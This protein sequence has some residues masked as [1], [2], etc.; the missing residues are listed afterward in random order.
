MKIIIDGTIYSSAP[1]GGVYRYFNE[2]IPRLSAFPDTEVNI[3]SPKDAN[4]IPTGNHI[5]IEKD[6]LPSGSWLPEGN[7]KN[8]LRKV[9]QRVNSILMS[10][11]FSGV[12]DSVFHSTYY[13]ASPWPDLPQVVTIHDMISELFQETYHL[14]H[15]K[16]LRENKAKCLKTATRVIAISEQTK[17]DLQK[18]Y[19]IPASKIDV[20]YHGC[21]FELFSK[22]E[23]ARSEKNI[24][25]K[26]S[27]TS[28]YFLYLG[29]RLHHKNFSN[30]L[31]AFAANP[32]SKDYLLAV[33]GTPWDPEESE[34]I[35]SLNI[36]SRLVWMP[37]LNEKELPTVYQNATAL[38]LPSYYE[39]F[40]LPL[41]EAMAAGC[42]VV[43]SQAGPFPELA[44]GAAILFDPFDPKQIGLALEEVSSPSKR[45][46]LIEKG[47]IQAAKFSWDLSAKKHFES[48]K[49]ALKN[50]A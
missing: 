14:P 18:I 27:L 9:K 17:R 8:N 43:A 26:H 42:P 1:S 41:I 47:K 7:L 44:E 13:T 32:I 11:K 48:Y 10:K 21:N 22:K 3:F 35:K 16:E 45:I 29:G 28:P 50:K 12:K 30:L 37:S 31:R 4:S 49:M 2:I 38:A 40:G 36:S 46:E 19:N 33:A 5:K 20:I 15:V 6:R 34:L 24:L 39:G 25:E 23:E